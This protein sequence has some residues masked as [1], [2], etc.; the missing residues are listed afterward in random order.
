M[1]NRDGHDAAARRRSV[2]ERFRK[3]FA[4]MTV[5]L[6][7]GTAGIWAKVEQRLAQRTTPETPTVPPHYTIQPMQQQ[8]QHSKAEPEG[9]K[10]A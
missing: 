3:S 10:K 6:A 5:Q 2:S 1:Q 8:Q 4:E 7:A 9:E